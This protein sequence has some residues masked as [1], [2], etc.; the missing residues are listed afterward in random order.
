MINQISESAEYIRNNTKYKP[1]LA[2]I[3]GSGLGHLAEEIED[4][5][6]LEYK[7]IPNFV[8]S[9]V[10]GHA[11]RL[12]FG[13]LEG[14]EVVMMQGRLHYYEGYDIKKITFPIRVF[15]E[16]GI[17]NLFITNA[18]GALNENFEPGNL[19]IIKDHIN[20]LFQNP[21]IGK[22]LDKYG[23]RFLDM[24]EAYNRELIDFAEKTAESIDIDVK[25]G[26]Y[27]CMSGPTYETSAEVKMLQKLGGDIVGMSTVP[28]VIVANHCDI[29]VLG[30][31]CA[32]NMATGIL[33]QPLNHEEVLETS[34]RVRKD[35]MKYMRTL[36][37]NM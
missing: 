14:K 18:A 32:T 30:I 8:V 17:E 26:V 11:G 19:V 13:K 2:L 12:V 21:L 22:N 23:P 37:K 1:K 29:D 6:I 5:E 10:K 34:K 31:S 20:M 15:K 36:I 33:D 4:K 25:K 3:L 9:T 27:I 28:E 24:S 16:I 35:F 7:D